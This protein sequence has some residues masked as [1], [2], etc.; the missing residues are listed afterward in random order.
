MNTCRQPNFLLVHMQAGDVWPELPQ[1]FHA[2]AATA[3]AGAHT[4]LERKAGRRSVSRRWLLFRVRRPARLSPEV[5]SVIAY[6]N[7]HTDPGSSQWRCVHA[8]F[9]LNVLAYHMRCLPR[10]LCKLY[11]SVALCSRFSIVR[12]HTI[13][14]ACFLPSGILLTGA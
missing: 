1:I 9:H 3:Q 4:G 10:A 5:S 2:A 6:Q 8:S 13:F 14:S 7:L 11:S 12:T